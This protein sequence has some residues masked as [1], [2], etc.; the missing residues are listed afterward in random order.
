MK[1][2]VSCFQAHFHLKAEMFPKN[3][4][5]IFQKYFKPIFTSAS[6]SRPKYFRKKYSDKFQKCFKPF[7]PPT[8][9]EGLIYFQK[10]VQICFKNSPFSPQPPLEAFPTQCKLMGRVSASYYSSCAPT[11]IFANIYKYILQLHIAPAALLHIF[12]YFSEFF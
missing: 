12:F 2:V 7:S 8:T 6:P 3:S 11:N 4:S 5:N 10:I 9:L 1:Y